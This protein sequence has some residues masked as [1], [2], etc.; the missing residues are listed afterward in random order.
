MSILSARATCPSNTV[1]AMKFTLA[2]YRDFRG[3]AAGKLLSSS[4]PAAADALWN[5]CDRFSGLS[6]RSSY[7]DYCSGVRA[8]AQEEAERLFADSE[9]MKGS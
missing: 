1:K 8:T 4:A 2:L 5:R 3:L 7:M 9:G 6:A